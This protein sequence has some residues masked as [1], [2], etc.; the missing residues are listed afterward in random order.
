MNTNR[1]GG[2]ASD[3]LTMCKLKD[4]DVD[5]QRNLPRAA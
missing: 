2:S 3:L 5:D 4:I 1:I